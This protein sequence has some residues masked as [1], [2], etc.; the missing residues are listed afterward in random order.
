MALARTVWGLLVVGLLGCSAPLREPASPSAPPVPVAKL[1]AGL[2]EVDITPPAGLSLFGYGPEGRV[3]RG[4][5]GRLRCRSLFVVDRRGE[6]LAWSVCDLGAIS[7]LLRARVARELLPI[8]LG[9]DR[10]LLSASHTHAGPAHYFSN[11]AYSG[12]F[13]S[14][15]PGF[16]AQVLSW[17]SERIASSIRAARADALS[18]AEAQLSWHFGELSQGATKNRS[19]LPHCKNPQPMAG[20]A[21]TCGRAGA[22]VL[23]VDRRLSVLRVERG[24]AGERRLLGLFAVVAMHPTTIPNTNELYHADVFGIAA[25]Q[26]HHRLKDRPTVALA[27]GIAGDVSPA[28]A[29]QSWAEAARLGAQLA[30]DVQRVSE[31]PSAA[32]STELARS[33]RE[34]TIAGPELCVDGRLGNS[35][36]GGPEDGR[37]RYYAVPVAREG[38]RLPEPEGCHGYKRSWTKMLS[39]STWAFPRFVPLLAAQLGGATV[40]GLPFELSTTAGLEL[41]SELEASG[42]PAVLVGLS[43][44]YLQY[45]TTRA[46]YDEQHYEGAS[47]LFGPGSSAFF[48]KHLRALMLGFREPSKV[49]ELN[50]TRAHDFDPSPRVERLLAA[51]PERPRQ[52]V[53]QPFQVDFTRMDMSVEWRVRDSSFFQDDGRETNIADGALVRIETMGPDGKWRPLLAELG[54]P[55]D[56]TG[57]SVWVAQRRRRGN[58][59]SAVWQPPRSLAGRFRFVI[60]RSEHVVRSQEFSL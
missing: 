48:S 36:A 49:P 38:A 29:Q 17:L 22:S 8:G 26:L 5:R 3:S 9:A 53:R 2:S 43:N 54:V 28:V 10:L 51:T 20:V 37:T 56:D 19:L 55:V 34:V 25:R 15:D 18:G 42:E 52:I 23:E 45:V 50:Q 39:S 40:L 35:A 1:S 33:Y 46:E 59:Y 24:T 30:A 12:R 32:S 16:D 11:R 31:Q 13:S 4:H 44:E 21:S 47:V 41:R 14:E 6:S 58:H 27:S 7:A 60:G 57:T